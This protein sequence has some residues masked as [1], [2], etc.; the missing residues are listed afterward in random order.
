MATNQPVA[1]G[2]SAQ[3]ENGRIV[4]MGR[5]YREK[6]DTFL[7]SLDHQRSDIRTT[8][9]AKFHRYCCFC[10]RHGLGLFQRKC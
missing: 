2:S 5:F 4:S 8:P 9:V 3:M 1:A 6:G 10:N 7:Q